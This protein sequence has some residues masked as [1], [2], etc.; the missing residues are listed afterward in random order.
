MGDC[1]SKKTKP[2]RAGLKS[3]F[4][5]EEIDL[6]T[7]FGS[8]NKAIREKRI[9]GNEIIDL[10]KKP[11]FSV[12]FG[13]KKYIINDKKFEIYSDDAKQ[14]KKPI[15]EDLIHCKTA[16]EKRYFGK[17]FNDNIHIQII[18]S[19][20]DL[21]KILAVYANNIVYTFN[22]L[23]R[24]DSDEFED[25]IGYISTI[26]DFDKY[27]NPVE[28]EKGYDNIVNSSRIFKEYRSNP[29]LG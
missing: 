8:G 20:L 17:T 22:N 29:R 24:K 14:S 3:S 11:R 19:I 26:N 10:Q 2:K 15:G 5:I 7:S 18:Y 23:Q 1:K 25:F 9:S 13:N 27:K 28:G 6:M 16:L 21:E 4:V 12:E